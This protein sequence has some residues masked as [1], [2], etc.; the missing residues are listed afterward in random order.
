MKNLL[1]EMSKQELMSL[2]KS[3]TMSTKINNEDR[4]KRISL[5]NQFIERSK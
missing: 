1:K 4:E 5:I 2:K 3:Q